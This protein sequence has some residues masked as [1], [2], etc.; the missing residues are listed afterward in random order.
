MKPKF[1]MGLVVST[2]ICFGGLPESLPAQECAAP[3]YVAPGCDAPTTN[4]RG[5]CVPRQSPPL[6]PPTAPQQPPA[7]PQAPPGYYPQPAAPQAATFQAPPA[8]GPITGESQGWGIRGMSLDFPAWHL[9]LPHLHFPSFFRTRQNPEMLIGSA[10]API[11]QGAAAPYGP[12]SGAVHIP[13]M[14]H[15]A[16]PYAPQPSPPVA[17]PV[18]PPTAP[19]AA[20][21]APR[22]PAPPA[23]PETEPDCAAPP[24]LVPPAAA[25]DVAGSGYQTNHAALEELR[26]A[27][28]ELSA[29]R[30]ELLHLK[31]LLET[32]TAQTPE[33]V[34]APPSAAARRTKKQP[35]SQEL[36]ETSPPRRLNNSPVKSA[37][38][39]DIDGAIQVSATVSNAQVESADLNQDAD[40]IQ[41]PR[42]LT[43]KPARPQA[44]VLAGARQAV[45]SD[46]SST[47]KTGRK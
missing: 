39:R 33:D 1:S 4:S 3:R 12:I 34:P 22:S 40:E 28:A 17:P 16:V 20:P 44:S 19:P 30:E 38:R 45:K 9:Q 11:V 25:C 31:E 7:A 21:Q 15:T 47:R 29:Y 32:V 6:A 42:N 2:A 18:A 43:K 13:G 37:P 27:R 10:R 5:R 23:A 46:S 24:P 36:A 41:V 26:A 35:A 8:T 14:S